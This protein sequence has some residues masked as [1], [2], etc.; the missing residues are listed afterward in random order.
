MVQRQPTPSRIATGP[1]TG[2][3]SE[4]PASLRQ[5]AQDLRLGDGFDLIASDAGWT[6]QAGQLG[7]DLVAG[8]PNGLLDGIHPGSWTYSNISAGMGT[9]LGGEAEASFEVDRAGVA[10]LATSCRSI[11]LD[12]SGTSPI[13]GDVGQSSCTVPDGLDAWIVSIVE[14]DQLTLTAQYETIGLWSPGASVVFAATR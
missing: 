5:Q 7:I 12:L 6:L 14:H 2:S 1:P 8:P 13:V 3:L 10:V 4:C 11:Q 9:S